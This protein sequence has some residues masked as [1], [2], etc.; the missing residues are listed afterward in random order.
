[1]AAN[2][3]QIGRTQENDIQFELRFRKY[4]ITNPSEITEIL[5]VHFTNIATEVIKNLI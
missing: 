1:M 2:K 3:K 5:N 4:L